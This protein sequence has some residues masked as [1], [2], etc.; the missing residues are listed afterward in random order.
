M[1]DINDYIKI[2][3][4]LKIEYQ[5]KSEYL[6]IVNYLKHHKSIE[7]VWHP[8]IADKSTCDDFK[9]NKDE[10]CSGV[11]SFKL[12]MQIKKHSFF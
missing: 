6:I 2:L 10:G 9:I 5:D 11:L 7:K 4:T 3:L 12:K 8:S 1:G